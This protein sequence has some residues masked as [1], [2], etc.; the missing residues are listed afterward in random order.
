MAHS[1][2]WGGAL[3]IRKCRDC[4]HESARLGFP[5]WGRTRCL[6]RNPT[7]RR[8]GWFQQT[9]Q[10]AGALAFRTDPRVADVVKGR[11]SMQKVLHRKWRRQKSVRP[12]I[13]SESVCIDA[14]YGNHHDDPG[15]GWSAAERGDVLQITRLVRVHDAYRLIRS[16]ERE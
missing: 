7:A 9:V 4:R 8:T 12:A 10:F 2:Y 6:L 16:I 13:W 15:A 5:G 3:S 14:C 11:Q 1:A